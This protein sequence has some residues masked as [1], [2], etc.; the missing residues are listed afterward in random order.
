MPSKWASA[1]YPYYA[2][3]RGELT[4]AEDRRTTRNESVRRLMTGSEG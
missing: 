1:I 2:Q 3:K 4:K